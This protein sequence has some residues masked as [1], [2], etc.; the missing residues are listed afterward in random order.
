MNMM[1]FLF[2]GPFFLREHRLYCVM[3][4]LADAAAPG[5]GR[6]RSTRAFRNGCADALHYVNQGSR[7]QE[8]LVQPAR[9]LVGLLCLGCAPQPFQRVALVLV[10]TLAG[11]LQLDGV[12]CRL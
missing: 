7:L 4:A 10:A 3:A 9:S 11:R 1:R 12:F 8:T 2:S 6:L 5:Q